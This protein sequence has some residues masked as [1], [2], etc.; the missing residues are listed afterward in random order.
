MGI[1]N[2]TSDVQPNGEPKIRGALPNRAREKHTTNLS[3]DTAN[4]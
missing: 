1:S 4:P 3:N 2:V